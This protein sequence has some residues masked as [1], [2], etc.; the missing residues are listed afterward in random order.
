MSEQNY[1]YENKGL[2]EWLI[3]LV[4]DDHKKRKIASEVITDQFY[5]PKHLFAT[6]PGALESASARF[7]DTVRSLLSYGTFPTEKF[8]NNLLSL[9]ITLQESWENHCELESDKQK[10]IEKS[11]FGESNETP[12]QEQYASYGRALRAQMEEVGAKIQNGESHENI[13][14]GITL[15]KITDLLGRELLPAAAYIRKMLGLKYHTHT[16]CGIIQRMES[17]GIEF[18]DDL[19]DC[20]KKEDFNYY[21]QKTLGVILKHHTEHIKEVVELLDDSDAITRRNAIVTL[22]NCGQEVTKQMPEVEDRLR[23]IITNPHMKSEWHYSAY[24]LASIAKETESVSLLLSL[25]YPIDGEN[26]GTAIDC[27]RVIHI[28][29]ERIVPRLVE[30]METFKEYDPDFMY[31]SVHERIIYALK[32]F[33]AEAA[34]AVPA[35]TKR[36]WAEPETHFDDDSNP[37]EVRNPDRLV[38]E[39]LGE[40]GSLAAEALPALLELQKEMNERI[41]KEMAGREEEDASPEIYEEETWDVAIRKI[42]EGKE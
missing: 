13:T 37:Y 41:A 31:Q 7:C 4:G 10:E 35:L 26:V 42:R 19:F 25:T 15:A 12:T 2:G 17:A 40:L 36:I 34:V 20:L 39:F 3:Q 27:F 33:G 6:A 29:D 16:A 38:I 11:I 30:L 18:Y 22:N 8:A 9:M 21:P 14:V 24:A 32:N 28:K 23:K 1:I 5:L